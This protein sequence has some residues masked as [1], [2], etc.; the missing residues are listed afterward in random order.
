MAG[1]GRPGLLRTSEPSVTGTVEAKQDGAAMPSSGVAWESREL[2]LLVLLGHS[3]KRESG[4][5]GPR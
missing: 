1:A 3:L 5:L 2:T 4:C